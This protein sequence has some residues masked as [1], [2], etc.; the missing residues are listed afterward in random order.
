MTVD[1]S[2][3]LSAIDSAY[4]GKF[5]DELKT[6]ATPIHDKK[7]DLKAAVEEALELPGTQTLPDAQGKLVGAGFEFATKLIQQLS[8]Q[9]ALTELL[10][11]RFAVPSQ[12]RTTLN[13]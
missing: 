9:P 5:G 4:E 6:L 10:D 7:D 2:H 12:M 3:Y 8:K 11:V 13:P 1:I